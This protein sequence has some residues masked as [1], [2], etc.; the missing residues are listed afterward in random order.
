LTLRVEIVARVKLKEK[1]RQ[2]DVV[3]ILEEIYEYVQE[4]KLARKK[5]SKGK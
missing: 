2:Q 5:I 1:K 3:T 4:K